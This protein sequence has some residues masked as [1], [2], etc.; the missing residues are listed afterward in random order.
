MIGHWLKREGQVESLVTWVNPNLGFHASSY[1]AA[2]W[3]YLGCEPTVYRY[4]NADYFTARQLFHRPHTPLL[5]IDTS[6]LRLAPLQVWHYR[7]TR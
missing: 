5:D 4:I 1:R 2:N 7:I 3:S 6:K